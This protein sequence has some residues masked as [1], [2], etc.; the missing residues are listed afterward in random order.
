MQSERVPAVPK[1]ELRCPGAPDLRLHI[2]RESSLERTRSRDEEPHRTIVKDI[3]V[4]SGGRILLGWAYGQ[5]HF[6]STP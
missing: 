2:Q 3:G 4:D 6:G 5:L 1:F